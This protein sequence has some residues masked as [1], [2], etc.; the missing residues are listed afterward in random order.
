MNPSTSQID[1]PESLVENK[2]ERLASLDQFRGYTVLGMLLVNY[3]GHHSVCPQILKHSHDYCSYADTIMPQFL[4]AVGFAMR[5]SFGKR[6]QVQGKLVAYAR[7]V[8]RLLGLAL[9]S[10]VIY[11]VGP[12]AANWSQLQELGL[13]QA[14]YAPLKRD[15]FQT[16]MHIAATSLWILPVV[17][18]KPSIRIGWMLGSAL[19]H[20]W[21]SYLFNFDWVNSAPRGI[22]GGPL[23]FL[24]WSIPALV[25]TLA[26]DV[27]LKPRSALQIGSPMLVR[28]LVASLLLMLLGYCL[29]CGTRFYDVLE[30]Q[31]D[32]REMEE[33]SVDPVLPSLVRIHAKIASAKEEELTA[34]FAEPPFFHP[35]QK[36]LRKWNYWMM[37]QRSGTLSYLVFSAG[38]SLLVFLVFFVVSDLLQVQLSIFR[39]LGTNA[40]MAYVLH[41]MISKAVQPFFPKDSPV[42]FSLIGLGIFLFVTWLFV[43]TMEK[44][45]VFVRI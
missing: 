13:W 43:R 28:V 26:C 1:T 12:R 7:M 5:L 18:C 34:W 11:N 24:T 27:F 15:W 8:R 4:F 33:I 6:L 29:S 36:N 19:L 3:F 21:V 2:T 30:S 38:F 41:L 42:W 16:L 10:M 45:G 23:G 20:V 17:H 44:Q 37:S 9:V 14:L 39:T 31:V 40:L 22:D 32:S 25:G 35:P